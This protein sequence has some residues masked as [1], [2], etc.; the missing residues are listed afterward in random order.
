MADFKEKY[1]KIV[2]PEIMKRH[3]FSSLLAV[4]RISK[5][6]V[7][8]GIGR[9][10]DDKEAELISKY[11][12]LICGQKASD[13]PA[14]KAIASFKT[15][16]GMRIGLAATL[17]GKRMYDFLSRLVDV[18]LPRTRDF[19]GI[20]EKSL[21]G[22]G[23]LTIGVREHI[24]FPEIIGEDVKHIFGMSVTLTTNAKNREIALEMFKLL[25]LP[26]R[27]NV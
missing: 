9:I 25:G 26:F 18:A 17:H 12:A 27:K 6:T 5:I 2:V 24:V 14:K 15:R 21:D 19:R 13:R 22:R 8:V 23:N 16:E 20:E 3:G 10:R 1:N 11:L 4:P 7:S